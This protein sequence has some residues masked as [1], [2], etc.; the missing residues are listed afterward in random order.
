MKPVHTLKNT[1]HF[2]SHRPHNTHHLMHACAS[3]VSSEAGIRDGLMMKASYWV[4][5]A[6]VGISVMLNEPGTEKLKKKNISI[7]IYLFS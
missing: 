3:P 6:F 7:L 1:S 5:S 2:I 4:Y